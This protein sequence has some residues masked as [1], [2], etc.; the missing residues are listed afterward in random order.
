MS[1]P[2]IECLPR[3]QNITTFFSVALALV[4]A[5][6]GLVI[7]VEPRAS[8]SKSDSTILA[9]VS[10]KPLKVSIS[11]GTA[12]GFA[13]LVVQ[14][15]SRVTG[16]VEPYSFDWQ[17]GDGTSSGAADPTHTFNVTG[18]FDTFSYSAPIPIPPTTSTVYGVVLTVTDS[19]GSS[20][21]AFAQITALNE[22]WTL[23][24][25]I[26]SAQPLD[27]SNPSMIEL[28]GSGFGSHSTEY[29]LGG[30]YVDTEWYDCGVS[31]GSLDIHDF[32]SGYDYGGY[33]CTGVSPDLFGV[34]LSWSSDSIGI[35]GFG[36]FLGFGGTPSPGS[37]IAVNI[38]GPNRDGTAVYLTTVVQGPINTVITGKSGLYSV[39][40]VEQGL[41]LG[42]NWS[43]KFNGSNVHSD[44]SAVVFWTANGTFPFKTAI[45]DNYSANVTSGT[46]TVNGSDVVEPVLFIYEG[47]PGSYSSSFEYGNS[48]RFTDS[49]M[50]PSRST[51]CSLTSATIEPES[52]LA[53]SDGSPFEGTITTYSLAQNY[54]DSIASDSDIDVGTGEESVAVLGCYDEKF[55]PD[56]SFTGLVNL[57]VNFTA[58]FAC[59]VGAAAGFDVDPTTVGSLFGYFG[60]EFGYFPDVF[61]GPMTGNPHTGC[62]AEVQG[63]PGQ[64]LELTPIAVFDPL[65]PNYNISFTDA[66]TAPKYDWNV[67]ISGV[68]IH[69]W[70]DESKRC[71]CSDESFLLPNGSYEYTISGPSGKRVSAIAPSGTIAVNG[72]NVTKSFDFVKGKT[73]SVTFEQSGLTGGILWCV[74][75]AGKRCSTS[76]TIQ[77][78][79]LTPGNYSYQ[80]QSVLGQSIIASEGGKFLPLAGTIEISK[81]NLSISLD[82]STGYAVNFQETGLPA[83]TNWSV[84]VVGTT[85]DSSNSTLSF[86][87]G[88]GTYQY[89]ISKVPGYKER[90]SPSNITVNGSPTVVTV[91]FRSA[92][93]P[94]QWPDQASNKPNTIQS[95]AHLDTPLTRGNP[96]E[97]ISTLSD[98]KYQLRRN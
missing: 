61:T 40:F 72:V 20:A 19:N 12:E 56:Q 48:W 21:N 60:G 30:G 32:S 38:F 27:V 50:C 51:S 69:S 5:A 37:L 68:G 31:T 6:A 93:A 26:D 63:I 64:S 47:V 70:I 74:E 90:S 78:L 4:I 95:L 28:Q 33:T 43:L 77:W 94:R 71:S 84:E 1:T 98:L 22:N 29:S 2:R 11:V 58:G 35:S 34:V 86:F 96:L 23:G 25:V 3:G 36:S 24:P 18:P 80:V 79:N 87:L 46:V 89:H 15:K 75:L 76:T 7:I 10:S 8:G 17:F 82:Y 81:K 55:V 39:A 9:A 83:G 73:Y 49:K 41:P 44:E 88:N 85:R 45:D 66:G 13:P 57:I 59:T 52:N 16:G 53:L 54:C 67:S 14:F 65:D 97:T 42:A 92:S 91:L 62:E